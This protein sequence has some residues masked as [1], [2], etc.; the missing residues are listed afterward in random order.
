[1]RR[2]AARKLAQR[3]RRSL[4]QP[5][6]LLLVVAAVV[7]LTWCAQP[8]SAYPELFVDN[9]FA[10]G[11]TSHPTTELGGHG[12]PQPDRCVGIAC[13]LVRR[14]CAQV[15]MWLRGVVVACAAARAACVRCSWCG[16]AIV[17]CVGGAVARA[18]VC[19]GRARAT[20]ASLGTAVGFASNR[21]GAVLH[22]GIRCC[23][24]CC[25][26]CCG[27]NECAVC[28]VLLLLLLARGRRQRACAAAPVLW[29]PG[30]SVRV[31]GRVRARACVGNGAPALAELAAAATTNQHTH[32]H[33]HT[34]THVRARARSSST[35]PSPRGA[36]AAGPH[37]LLL[38]VCGSHGVECC[39]VL[40]CG[41]LLSAVLCCAVLCWVVLCCVVLCCLVAFAQQ[42]TSRSA[43]RHM[44]P[45]AACCAAGGSTT[46]PPT[47]PR[48]VH[49]PSHRAPQSHN[50]TITQSHNHTSHPHTQHHHIHAD[51]QEPG[52]RQGGA[53]Q[54]A[55][56]W[57]DV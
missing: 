37:A 57:C 4:R 47:H 8:T 31:C 20:A 32:T 38:R 27:H 24:R 51:A 26:C 19:A 55:V 11:C 1:M 42:T 15:C 16:C 12:A 18:V 13:G 34:H 54:G 48:L 28:I 9:G 40:C 39:A 44:A 49:P 41:V 36:C 22:G 17:W 56:P 7:L 25:C 3:G 29:A 10:T 45:V 50:H 14:M 5:T 21:L 2:S 52:R 23:C 53:C 46:H 6:N 43:H 33:T 30:A 35:R